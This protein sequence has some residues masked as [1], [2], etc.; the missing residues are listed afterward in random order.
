MRRMRSSAAELLLVLVLLAGSPRCGRHSDT[1]SRHKRAVLR[2]A[3]RTASALKLSREGRGG[4]AASARSRWQMLTSV[5]HSHPHLAPLSRLSSKLDS[6]YKALLSWAWLPR[7]RSGRRTRMM[8]C[9]V[10]RMPRMAARASPRPQL[11]FSRAVSSAASSTSS[12]SSARTRGALAIMAA[13]AGTAAGV[14]LGPTLR[15]ESVRALK[16]LRAHFADCQS[17]Q[18]P[19]QDVKRAKRVDLEAKFT[20]VVR[21]QHGTAAT[22]S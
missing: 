8:R 7:V 5:T 4:R 16:S 13:V 22:A 6:Y 20:P 2:C 1:L 19:P 11:G 9:S 14:A 21:V 17:L 12:G 3:G 18:A 15:N 10:A